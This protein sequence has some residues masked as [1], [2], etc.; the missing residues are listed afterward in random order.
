MPLGMEVGDFLLDGDGV[1]PPQK[2]AEFSATSIVANGCMDQDAAWYVG[3]RR[4]TRWT[5]C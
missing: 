5:L 4:P 1:L 2:G 3:S